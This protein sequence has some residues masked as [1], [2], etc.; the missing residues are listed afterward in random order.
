MKNEKVL[1][2]LGR[3]LMLLGSL[4]FGALLLPGCSPTTTYAS[5]WR[6]PTAE[7]LNLKGQLVAAVVMIDDEANRRVAE[8]TLASEITHYGAK[9]V[10]MYLIMPGHKVEDEAVAKAAIE[11]AGIKGVVVM[12]PMGVRQEVETSQVYTGAYYAGGYYGGYWGG[13]YG[14]GWGNAWG[15]PVSPYRSSYGP[16]EAYPY[17]GAV[18]V[19]VGTSETYSTTT[20]IIMVETLV[21]S[22]AQ[23]QLVWAGRSETTDRPK[24]Q[25]FVIELA[26]M[27]AREL[28]RLGL[29]T[30]G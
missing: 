13:Y 27:T 1:G 12:R 28:G 9:G 30:N 16:Q 11:K 5:S 8:D 7:P 4:S 21:Y 25:V 24:L 3:A 26:G 6:N 17:A 20:E 2:R 19:G 14:Y 29:L 10:P 18:G 15:A 22:L 23:N